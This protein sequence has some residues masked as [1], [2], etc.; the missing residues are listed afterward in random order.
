LQVDGFEKHTYNLKYADRLYWKLAV[1]PHLES[2]AGV[3]R[4]QSPAPDVHNMPATPTALGERHMPAAAHFRREHFPVPP[5]DPAA[6]RLTLAGAVATPAIVT[7]AELRALPHRAQPVVLECAGHRRAELAP[8]VP[9]LQWGV[10]A[11][12]EAVWAGVPL[13]DLLERAGIGGG[14]CEVVLH[15]ADRGPFAG[16]P[17][18]HAYARSLPLRKAL[19]P[20]TILAVEMNGGPIPPEHGGP[21][22]AIVPG[23]YA[24]DSVKWLERIQVSAD[25]FD[26]PFQA[27]DYRF[28]TIDD[29]GPGARMERMP[30]HSLVTDPADAAVLDPGAACVRGIA[31]SGAGAV[32]RVDVRVDDEPWRA[33]AIVARHGRHGR[34]FWEHEWEAAPGPHTIAVR[35]RDASG[36]VQPEQPVWN[37]RGYVVNAVQRLTVNVKEVA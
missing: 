8:T 26:G 17:G 11:V 23:W 7:L 18:T 15:G 29:P 19:D 12:S 22:R 25:E 2:T 10:G 32:T 33:A 13:R 27:L 37:R 36:A 16:L 31:W 3:A 14:A 1:E 20:D 21:V 24:T 34:T 35:A 28:A 30:V 6:W 9:G 5:V 4:P